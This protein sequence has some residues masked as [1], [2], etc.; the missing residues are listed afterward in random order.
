[1]QEPVYVVFNPAS[2][3]G[4]GSRLVGPFLKALASRGAVV[5]HALTTRAG[6]EK[7][8][9]RNAMARGLRTIV[10][11][12]GDGT[13]S[14]VG[15]AIV[16]SGVD[17]RLG[18]VPG[19]TGCDLAKSLGIPP[20]NLE[21][22]ADIILNG[23]AQKIDVGRIEGQHFLNIVGFGF[24]VAVL[25]D[26]WGVSYLGGDLLYL[27]CALR[28][29]YAFSG[30]AVEVTAEGSPP[31]RHELLMLVIAN[32]QVF[33]GGFKIAPHADLADGRLDG[34]A[35]RNMNLFRRLRLMARLSRGTH[36]GSPEVSTMTS[37][38]FRLRFDSPPTYERDGEWN[39]ATSTELT[40]DTLPQAL[41]LLVPRH[42]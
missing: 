19:G 37:P 6:E 10:A 28:Q 2:G 7:D 32:A 40:L 12:G 16:E 34:V 27:Y 18:L 39:R 8:L 22:C 35:F 14:N 36:A 38:S 17:A 3:K 33:G 41:S 13:W 11:V 30:F 21:A 23:Q 9:A 29:I 26:S 25:E 5:E 4:R 31:K 1:L 15:G 20:H 24:D 42:P